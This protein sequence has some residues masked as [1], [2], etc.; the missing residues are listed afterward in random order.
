MARK[1]DRI[2]N[3]TENNLLALLSSLE[4]LVF[5]VLLLALGLPSVHI[6]LGGAGS[7]N[8]TVATYL[9]VGTVTPEILAIIVDNGNTSID[10]TVNTTKLV[11]FYVIARDFNNETDIQNVTI[12]FFDNVAS[13]FGGTDDNND[14]YTNQTCTINTA[15]GNEYEIIANCTIPVWY[16]ANNQTWNVTATV[17]DNVSLSSS[18]SN[19]TTINALLGFSLPDSIDYGI[20]NSTEVSQEQIA[21]V[22]N[23]GNVYANLSLSGYAVTVGDGFA[24]NCTQ[25]SVQNI[26]IEYERYNLTASNDSNLNYTQYQ[27][28]YL[29]LSSD[30]IVRTF[31]VPQRQNDTGQFFDDTNA[32]Y[33]RIYV[34][35]GVAGS[36]SGN[37]VFGAVQADGT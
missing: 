12:E 15:Y 19:T 8:T 35:L 10:L 20:V 33:W 25:G 14:H 23:A 21:N 2:E 16:Y 30:P 27:S 17:T 29:N 36:C 34:P 1:D 6:V 13:S 11:E 24:M 9:Q 37:I 26:S 28:I 31:N 5:L 4:F 32:S 22:T 3:R 18:G 7:P